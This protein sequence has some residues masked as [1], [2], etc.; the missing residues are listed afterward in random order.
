ML[1]IKPEAPGMLGKPHTTKPFP[2]LNML[3]KNDFDHLKV[4]IGNIKDNY[5]KYKEEDHF[6]NIP[7]LG[8]NVSE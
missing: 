6:N 3:F 4:I 2:A 5:R 8:V 1:G 7:A